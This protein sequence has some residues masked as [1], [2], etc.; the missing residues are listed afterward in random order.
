MLKIYLSH[1]NNI[2]A[3]HYLRK[4]FPNKFLL[5]YFIILNAKEINIIYFL[6]SENSSG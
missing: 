4:E 5:M 3:L 6:T 2:P 1:G